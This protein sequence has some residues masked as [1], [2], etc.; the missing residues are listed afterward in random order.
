[1]ETKSEFE[2]RAESLFALGEAS[3]LTAA[4]TVV[5]AERPELYSEY[6][7]NLRDPERRRI[8]SASQLAEVD[9]A[10]S[11][12]QLISGAFSTPL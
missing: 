7:A 5:A 12:R 4:L 8:T 1:M 2:G 3:S 9:H 6:L 11:D 10:R